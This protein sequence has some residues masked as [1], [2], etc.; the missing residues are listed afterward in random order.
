MAKSIKDKLREQTKNA[1]LE[2]RKEIKDEVISIFN[3]WNSA[4]KKMH[5][6]QIHH[7][8]QIDEK[9]SQHQ[10][11]LNS[12]TSELRSTLS[13]TLNQITR[14]KQ[15]R[16]LKFILLNIAVAIISSITTMLFIDWY[17]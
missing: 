14:I 12:A 15:N 17:F 10:E 16:T 4:S 3:E 1:Q 8:T 5:N 11:E 13:E 9:I 6:L 7:F 2:F